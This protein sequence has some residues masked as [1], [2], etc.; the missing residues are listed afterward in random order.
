MAK[1]S[2]LIEQHKQLKALE[3]LVA[4]YLKRSLLSSLSEKF[5]SVY[6]T[7]EDCNN[8]SAFRR[9]ML[10]LQYIVLCN[11]SDAQEQ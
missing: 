4:S 8:L 10:E 5:T 9:L 11:F 7:S 6:N 1:Q 3:E 2:M